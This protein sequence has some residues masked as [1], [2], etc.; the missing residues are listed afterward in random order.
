MSEDLP[1]LLAFARSYGYN[2]AAV[3]KTGPTAAQD[4]AAQ[5]QD[6][7]RQHA[8]L[9]V[10]VERVPDELLAVDLV[11]VAGL[12][13]LGGTEPRRRAAGPHRLENLS[14]GP[15]LPWPRHL[16][17]ELDTEHVD[18]QRPTQVR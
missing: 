8:Q 11:G 15:A 13:H 3:G 12:G 16:V 7:V 10:L 17:E 2:T 4:R 14:P 18:L 1:T 6:D 5:R 9:V